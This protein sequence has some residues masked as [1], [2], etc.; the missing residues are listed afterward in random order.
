MFQNFHLPDE[1]RNFSEGKPLEYVETEKS[2]VVLH[3]LEEN[4]WILAVCF[5]P[6]LEY[7]FYS[8]AIL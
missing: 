1:A 4:W 8:L 5:P 6:T 3:E 2:R 7:I